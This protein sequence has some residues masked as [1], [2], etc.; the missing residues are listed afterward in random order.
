[1]T[2]SRHN[3]LPKTPPP[4][5]IIL[6]EDNLELQNMNLGMCTAA[7]LDHPFLSQE[8]GLHS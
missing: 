4:N 5:T 6:E 8:I 3:H 1:M 2:S 7:E